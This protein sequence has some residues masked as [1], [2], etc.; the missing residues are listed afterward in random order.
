MRHFLLINGAHPNRN[1]V[2]ALRF[3]YL[4]KSLALL[5]NEVFLV[6]PTDVACRHDCGPVSEKIR[7]VRPPIELQITEPAF[8]HYEQI[9]AGCVYHLAI[10]GSKDFDKVNGLFSVLSRRFFNAINW[11]TGPS[12]DRLWVE[13][14]CSTLYKTGILSKIDLIWA[15]FSPIDC[16]TIGRKMSLEAKV[17]L[18][19]DVKDSWAHYIP[20]SL[21]FIVASRFTRIA[22]QTA[23]SNLQWGELPWLLNH[24]RR[25]VI[26]SGFSTSVLT[27][28]AKRSEL[29]RSEIVAICFGRVQYDDYYLLL[30]CMESWA[31]SKGQKVLVKYWGNNQESLLKLFRGKVGPVSLEVGPFI[32]AKDLMTEAALADFSFYPRSKHGAIHHKATEL[33]SSRR[34]ILVWGSEN[35]E[36]IKLADQCNIPF[37]SCAGRHDVY[38]A[39]DNILDGKL[40]QEQFG[41]ERELARLTWEAQGKRLSKFFEEIIEETPPQ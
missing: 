24:R 11:I 25:K 17:P 21:S 29:V 31:I 38:A 36:T 5:G 33:L 23:N 18:V 27:Q 15:G 13:K 3:L 19:I 34:P 6:T 26:Y 16:W 20:L 2:S 22:G 8:Q 41:D 35:E 30:E 1:H 37:Y 14:C 4:A 9:G 28:L 39:L 32:D 10:D 40:K 12:I 7:Q